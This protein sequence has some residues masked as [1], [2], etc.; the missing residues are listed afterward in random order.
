MQGTAEQFP[1]DTHFL[2]DLGERGREIYGL[3]RAHILQSKEDA[4]IKG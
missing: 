4:P 3:T 1:A 2:M